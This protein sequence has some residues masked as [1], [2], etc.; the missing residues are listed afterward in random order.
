MRVA[1]AYMKA[2]T[3]LLLSPGDVEAEARNETAVKL[4]PRLKRVSP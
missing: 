4:Y 3:A 2:A 1:H